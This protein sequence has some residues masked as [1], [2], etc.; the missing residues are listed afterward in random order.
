MSQHTE[1]GMLHCE[2]GMFPEKCFCLS[3]GFKS[4]FSK[5]GDK[6]VICL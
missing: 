5:I 4:V 3:A 6:C 1:W 2:V